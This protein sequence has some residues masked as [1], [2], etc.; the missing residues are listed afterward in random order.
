MTKNS[1]A[2]VTLN[3]GEPY[4]K[5]WRETFADTWFEYGKRH[6]YDVLS[7]EDYIDN[8]ELA[9]AR[10]PHWQKCLILEDPRTQDYEDVVWVDSDIL[11]N[12]HTAP[13]VVAA[14]A[15]GAASGKIGAVTWAG[16]DKPNRERFENGIRRVWE[17]NQAPWVRAI[18]DPTFQKFFELGGYPIDHENMMNTGLLV[19]KQCDQHRLAMRQVYETYKEGPHTSKEQMALAHYLL[20]KDMVN[21]IDSRFNKIWDTV[22][23][24]AYPFLL[25]PAFAQDKRMSAFCV[26]AAYHNAFFLHFIS[27]Q[28]RGFVGLVAKHYHWSDAWAA[29][30][31]Y[32]AEQSSVAA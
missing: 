8:S 27:G 25:V 29:I 10:S 6:G 26:N 30:Q 22:L 17:N 23:I 4:Q 1:K 18:E 2:L 21:P 24:E 7:L 28:S 20:T 15:D 9:H 14:N 5:M 32:F 16:S 12:Y 3:I 13:C 19:L 11:I 31:Q